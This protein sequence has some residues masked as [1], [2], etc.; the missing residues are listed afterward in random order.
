MT[1]HRLYNSLN[2]L[3]VSIIFGSELSRKDF[4]LGFLN[5]ESQ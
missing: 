4:L 1:V 3:S 2:K 5:R